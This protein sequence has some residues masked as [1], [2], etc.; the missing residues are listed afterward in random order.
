M[1][2]VAFLL[3][4]HVAIEWRAC[5]DVDVRYFDRSIGILFGCYFLIPSSLVVGV[6][7]DMWTRLAWSVQ[8]VFALFAIAVLSVVVSLWLKWEFEID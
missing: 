1:F 8:S 2:V 3:Q 7:G 5:N 6:K 4:I